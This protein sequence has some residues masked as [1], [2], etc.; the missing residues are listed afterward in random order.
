VI[1]VDLD[2]GILRA[3]GAAEEQDVIALAEDEEVGDPILEGLGPKRGAEDREQ[4]AARQ[5]S[6]R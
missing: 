5:G 6:H 3:A 1:A 2:A 4:Q